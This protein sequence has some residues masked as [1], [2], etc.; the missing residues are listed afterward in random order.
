MALI[1]NG[2]E[3]DDEVIEGEFRNVKGHYE[4]LLQVACCERDQEFRD[5]RLQA[6]AAERDERRDTQVS[7]WRRVL[8]G[9][10]TLGLGVLRAP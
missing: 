3:I 1:I 8:A 5:D 7:A 6:K 4:R 10:D 9:S 2:E